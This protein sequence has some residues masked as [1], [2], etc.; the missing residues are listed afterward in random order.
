MTEKS[1]YKCQCGCNKDIPFKPS[2]RTKVSR[3]IQGHQHLNKKKEN[4]VEINGDQATIFIKRRSGEVVKTVIDTDCVE[5]IKGY[6]WTSL[7]NKNNKSYYIKA[8][9]KRNGK[10]TSVTL[11]RLLMN[12]PDDKLVDHIN[13][14]TLDNRLKNL[15]IVTA[16]ENSQNL[17]GARSHSKSGIRGVFWN[18][19][20]KKWQV[21]VRIEGK[22]IHI[23]YFKDIELARV[24][25]AESR[26]K[27]LPFSKEGFN[28]TR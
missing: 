15:R 9:I 19:E 27:Y 4:K 14:D 17:K 3:F 7:W 21:Q 5:L 10:V 1:I 16:S 13:H 20:W 12:A 18:K 28:A 26:R 25:A 2:H 22:L 6:C 11:H 23:G 8:A 24:A